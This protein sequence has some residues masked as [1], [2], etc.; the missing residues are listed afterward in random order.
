MAHIYMVISISMFHVF[1]SPSDES[2]KNYNYRNLVT[3][4]GPIITS[5]HADHYTDWK[6]IW[7]LPYCIIHNTQVLKITYMP[8]I[9]IRAIP[10]THD[11][12]KSS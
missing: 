11:P 6:Y 4:S 3:F 10:I 1:H 9:H 12:A 7:L 5:W 8:H 2:S